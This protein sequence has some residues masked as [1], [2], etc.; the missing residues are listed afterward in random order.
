MLFSGDALFSVGV[1]RMFEGTPGPMWQGLFRLKALPPQTLLYCGHE[2]TLSNLRF[3]LS[4]DAENTALR[5]RDIEARAER[6]VDRLTVPISLASEFASNP[7]LRAD[8]PALAAAAGLVDAPPH[9]VFAALRRMK[10]NFRG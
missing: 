9:E 8:T 5:A 4:V 6:A 10:D 7:F 3:A 1:G 2:Y